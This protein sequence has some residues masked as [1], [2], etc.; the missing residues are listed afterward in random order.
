MFDN[1]P[2]FIWLDGDILP[3]KEARVHVMTH[4]LHYASSVYEGLR[5][6]NNKLFKAQDHYDRM[7]KSAGYL[8][9]N[10]PSTTEELI[11]ATERLNHIGNFKEGYVRAIAW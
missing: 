3:W 2:G 4:A 1:L 7:L 10:I 9:F 6:Y 8:D 11:K 5:F